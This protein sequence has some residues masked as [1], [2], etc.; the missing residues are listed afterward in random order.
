MTRRPI[1]WIGR[2][3]AAVLGLLVLVLVSMLIFQP[4]INLDRLRPGVEQALSRQ[5]GAA[6]SIADI[7]LRVSLWPQLY[8]Q[9]LRVST[10][11]D[12]GAQNLARVDNFEARI[13]LLPLVRKRIF[14][15]GARVDGCEFEVQ[16]LLALLERHRKPDDTVSDWTWVGVRQLE[17]VDLEVH[18]HPSRGEEH[19]I[20]IT[21]LSGGVSQIEPLRMEIFG[22]I[23]G[24]PLEIDLSG[25]P[26]GNLL[27]LPEVIP[28]TAKFELGE[29]ESK[30]Q[31]TVSKS[32]VV[33][34]ELVGR[35]EGSPFSGA[36]DVA[37]SGAR[38]R[39]SGHLRLERL[40]VGR[41][42]PTDEAGTEGTAAF[43]S[44]AELRQALSAIELPL[45]DLDAFDTDLELEVTSIEE[46]PV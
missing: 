39:I 37:F 33:I 2:S 9:G 17:A 7:R 44:L 43:T 19:E 35:F 46:L 12:Q 3:L 18:H 24:A 28:V 45:D 8:L 13:S 20:D 36:F 11:D 42:L 10:I 16:P 22:R 40:G 6:V 31:V 32:R 5:I 14:V 26:I 34:D 4:T 1:V 30:A 41:W 38:P 27:R 21:T 23:D 25:P 15:V 29:V